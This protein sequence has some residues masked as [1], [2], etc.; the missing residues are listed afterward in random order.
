MRKTVLTVTA[1]L[2]G[3]AWANAQQSQPGVSFVNSK[4]AGS[5][6]VTPTVATPPEP[7]AIGAV[8]APMS[9]PG[10]QHPA[11][12]PMPG[13][14]GAPMG[15]P[16]G[17]PMPLGGIPTGVPMG[18]P[19][20]AGV[21]PGY[22]DPVSSFGTER[23]WVGGY[24]LLGYLSRAR[25]STPLVTTGS[26]TDLHPG[27]LGEPSTVVLFG[28]DQYQFN[29]VHGVR[30]DAGVNLNDRLYLEG[31]VQYFPPSHTNAFFASDAAGNP[32]ISRPVFNTL[33]NQERSFLTTAPGLIAGATSVETRLELFS[34]EAHARYQWNPT[35]YCS[36]D[37]LLGYRRMQLEEDIVIRDTLIPIGGSITFVGTPITSGTIT[38]FDRFATTNQFNG[39]NVGTRFRW[40]SGF[41][42]FA[43]TAHG[44]VAVGATRQTTEIEGSSTATTA[45]GTQMVPGGVLALSSNIGHHQR[46][47]FGMVPEGGAGLIFLLAPGVRFHTGYTATYWNNVLRAG[48]QIDR[49][50][51]PA[52]VP[53]DVN[54]GSGNPGA[55][56]SN[57]FHGRALWIQS[58]HFGFEF[59]Y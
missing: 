23:I 32:F 27:A 1:I 30:V 33:F 25:L 31:S 52:L 2:L 21:G 50:V 13:M 8:P 18:D 38:D 49:R 41:Q 54:F 14:M 56:P 5:S 43:L 19:A 7:V 28:N 46:T 51:N 48:D 3:G 53:T 6:V 4:P 42:W 58:L 57:E 15:M 55:F 24:Y 39:V 9:G 44:K 26:L 11:Y 16:I 45:A 12:P 22:V 10:M 17:T 59:Y 36:W 47:V 34:I 35:P 29:Q 40:Q 20:F 37:V